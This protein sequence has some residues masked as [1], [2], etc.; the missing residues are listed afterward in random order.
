MLK[1]ATEDHIELCRN[2]IEIKGTLEDFEQVF[3]AKCM[4]VECVRSAAN[5]S[6]WTQRMRRQ[7]EALHNPVFMESDNPLFDLL[8][9]QGFASF[10][11]KQVVV[12][13]WQSFGPDVPSQEPS[14][15]VVHQGDIP[16]E[17]RDSQKVAETVQALR[18]ASDPLYEDSEVPAMPEPEPEPE[19]K[20][21]EAQDPPQARP[22]TP[23]YNT[24][25]PKGGIILSGGPVSS[26]PA[27]TTVTG[28]AKVKPRENDPWAIKGGDDAG[29]TARKKLK[30]RLGTKKKNESS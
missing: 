21:R 23:L 18:K 3:C 13:D 12:N 9:R 8:S 20:A 10:D 29:S 27:P 24:P 26:K 7:E 1:R 14:D 30:V 4:T 22:A 19:P 25:A 5:G 15:R 11:Q 16:T 17:T 2:S 6:R 28:N